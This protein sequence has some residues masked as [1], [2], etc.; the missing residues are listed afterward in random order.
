MM[1][2]LQHLTKKIKDLDAGAACLLWIFA[3]V[4]FGHASGSE[5]G[6]TLEQHLCRSLGKVS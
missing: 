2:R 6:G 1:M 5:E 3:V 4:E